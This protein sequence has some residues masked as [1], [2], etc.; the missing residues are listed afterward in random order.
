MDQTFQSSDQFANLKPT[1][2]I[3]NAVIN[4]WARSKETKIAP[5]RVEQI[6]DWMDQLYRNGNSSVKADKYT[7]NTC[8]HT[9]AKS[10]AKDAAQRAQQLLDRMHQMYE[11]GDLSAKPDTISYNIVINV[12]KFLALQHL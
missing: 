6:L 11:D 1:T 3:F 5:A 8:L 2:G 4:S 9:Y 12:S 7:Y 10:G